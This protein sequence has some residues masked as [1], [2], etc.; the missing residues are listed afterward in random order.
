M[1][2]LEKWFGD[3]GMEVPVGEDEQVIKRSVWEKRKERK[4]NKKK[5]MAGQENKSQWVRCVVGV[6]VLGG[7]M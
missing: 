7:H 3:G 5:G 1:T 6:N 4:E 2:L